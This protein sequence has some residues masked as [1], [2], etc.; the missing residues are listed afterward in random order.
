MQ[1]ERQGSI[2]Q[3]CQGSLVC[4]TALCWVANKEKYMGHHGLCSCH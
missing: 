3:L 4:C 2:T 1:E